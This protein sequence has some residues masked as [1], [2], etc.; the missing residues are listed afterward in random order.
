MSI[1]ATKSDEEMWTAFEQ[2]IYYS[3]P[4]HVSVSPLKVWVLQ[5]VTGGMTGKE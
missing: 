2:A 3:S 4:K 5:D 1:L